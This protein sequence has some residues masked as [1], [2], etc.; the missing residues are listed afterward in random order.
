MRISKPNNLRTLFMVLAVTMLPQLVTAQEVQLRATVDRNSVAVNSRFEYKIEVSGASTSLPDPDFPDF[1]DFAVLSG[2][3]SSTSIQ[4]INGKMSSSKSLTFYLQPA[5]VGKFT[6]APA[7]VT[8]DGKTV[9]SNPVTIEVVAAQAAGQSNQNQAANTQ[10]TDLVGENLLLKTIVDAKS[11]Y[12]NEQVVVTYKLYFRLQIRSY[13]FE[14]LPANPGFWS[15]DFKMPSQPEVS[16]EVINGIAWQTAVLRKVALFP[17]RSGELKVEPLTISVDAMVRQRRRSRSVFD[18]FFDDPFGKTVRKE[19][20]SEPITIKV[21]PLPSAGKPADFAGA[22]GNFNLSLQQDKQQVAV[23]EA[24]SLKMTLSGQGNIKLVK[25]PVLKIPSTI[26]EYDPRESSNVINEGNVIRGSKTVEYILVPRHAGEYTIP[27][28]EFS[29]FDTGR[30]KYVTTR[31][32]PVRLTVTPGSELPGGAISGSGLSKQEVEVLGR[33][34][35]FIKE[36]SAITPREE[37]LYRHW[38][39]YLIYL[40]PAFILIGADQYRKH[41]EILR[42]DVNFARS[43]RAGKMA[44]KHLTQA[45]KLLKSGEQDQFYRAVSAALQGFVCDKLSLQLTDF[46]EQLV[47]TQLQNRG[48]DQTIIDQYADCLH[49]SDFRQFSGTG[50]GREEREKFFEQAKIVLTLLEKSL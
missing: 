27:P 9:Q 16:T 42:K 41:N 25:P 33:D 44:A 22:V 12:Q 43:R 14:K 32:Q 3:N 5:A 49:E 11:V 29:Y 26:E 34:I 24:V 48:A 15:E 30:K 18:D 1:S 46:N 47:R 8:V 4:F 6:I 2:P 45:G 20:K 38:W 10:D 13:N 23:N 21:Q 40:L 50:A 37:L 31:T 19:L 7:R 28:A 39:Y 36:T 17:T 35:R